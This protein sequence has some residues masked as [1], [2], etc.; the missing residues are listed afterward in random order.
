[1]DRQLNIQGL[2]ITIN[3]SLD[4]SDSINNGK[5][6]G[7][8]NFATILATAVVPTVIA[9]VPLAAEA[10]AEARLVQN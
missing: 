4:N 2:M 8:S 5:D 10:V 7:F 6:G 9:S 3:N 1:M